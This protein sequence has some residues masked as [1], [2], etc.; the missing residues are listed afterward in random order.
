LGDSHMDLPSLR[1][2]NVDKL[3]ASGDI[4]GLL[5]AL[6]HRN[7]GFRRHAAEALSELRHET[8][9]EP[10]IAAL[11]DKVPAVRAAAARALGTQG[12]R[13]AVEPLSAALTDKF[14]I[15]QAAAARALGELGDARAFDARAVE[16]LLAAPPDAWDSPVWLSVKRAL[17]E[18]LEELGEGAADPLIEALELGGERAEF[19]LDQLN[20]VYIRHRGARAEEAL[21]KIAKDP[22]RGPAE[23]DRARH[24]LELVERSRAEQAAT[25]VASPLS[26]TAD[27]VAAP[28]SEPHLPPIEEVL[29]TEF[30]T[31]FV[32]LEDDSG[33]GGELLEQAHSAWN[34]DNDKAAALYEQALE[35]GL[36]PTHAA[37]AL[38]KIGE[39]HLGN[40]ELEEGVGYLLRCLST[41][42]ISPGVAH[43][44]AVRLEI[45]Y[46]AAGRAD[47]AGAVARVAAATAT[48]GV[49]FAYE[50]AE[51]LRALVRTVGAR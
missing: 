35:K 51:E 50:A 13:R 41:R 8:A 4:P 22:D 7:P 36:T 30:A 1:P 32:P 37:G 20:L 15:V 16:P 34:R 10:L 39:V 29:P 2:P 19:A 45:I 17:R 25:E 11:A 26:E 6:R 28:T 46:A 12:D 49:V 9:V 43:Q 14:D 42:P 38:G 48:P 3:R 23:R 47:E 21:H 40:G 18:V 27:P 24:T 5:K 44:A 31:E 33:P